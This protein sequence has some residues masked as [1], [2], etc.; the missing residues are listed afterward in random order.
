MMSAYTEEVDE[1]EAGVAE[2]LAALDLG[3][4]KRNSVG[5]ATCHSDFVASGFVA[6]LQKRLPFDVVGMTTMTSAN[7]LGMGMYSF[8]LTVLTSDELSFEA[9][10]SGPLDRGGYAGQIASAY[11]GAEEKLGGRPAF[12]IAL[13]P[14]LMDL[15][16]WLLHKGLCAACGG[17]PVWGGTAT[18]TDAGYDNCRTFVGGDS[19]ADRLAMVLVRGPVEPEFVVVSLPMQN[20]DDNRGMVTRSEGYLLREINGVPARRYFETLGLT[21]MDDVP[22]AMPLMLYHEGTSEPVALSIYSANDDGSLCCGDEIPEGASVSIGE[23][24]AEGVVA[25]ARE[26]MDRVLACGKRGGALILPCASRFLM[27]E[28]NQLDEMRTVAS[29]LEGG[30]AMPFMGGYSGGEIC[31]MRDGGG[32][33]RN[34]F[35][36]FTFTACVL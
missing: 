1:P 14:L 28:P 29:K 2:I 32:A 5:I 36:N 23:I 4:L 3:A 19:G 10:L 16:V 27:L 31:P 12:A 8:S 11:S 6:A 7:A 18:H 34:R 35:H 13:F 24:T 20:I 25:S 9:A 17:V 33:L 22:M 21:I 30:A 15:G 26:A